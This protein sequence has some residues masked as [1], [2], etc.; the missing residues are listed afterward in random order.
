VH[1]SNF[2]GLSPLAAG[3]L[4]PPR[5]APLD[6]GDPQPAMRARLARLSAEDMVAPRPIRDRQ[7]AEA[8]LAALWL[9]HDF[10]DE[11]HTIAQAI[12]T[13]EASYWHA[14][15]HRREG[16]YSNAKYWVRRA[17]PL[18]IFSRLADEAR[19]QGQLAFEL[20]AATALV[21]GSKWNA[22]K[23][24]DLCRA[25]C[26]R[27]APFDRPEALHW[28]QSLQAMEWNA[29]FSHCLAAALRNA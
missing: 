24:V 9:Y 22:E 12:E 27:Q 1:A 20:V 26:A 13:P 23:W 5:S 15:M 25:A 4:S 18:P 14:I 29:L 3:L 10:L 8:C 6:G 19:S 21:T 2:D 17:G 16:D 28:A 7:Q 11:A